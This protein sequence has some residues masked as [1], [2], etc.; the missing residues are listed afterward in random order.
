[1]A[2]SIDKFGTV[3]SSIDIN[4]EEINLILKSLM[5]VHKETKDLIL[6]DE[7][8]RLMERFLDIE[9]LIYGVENVQ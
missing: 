3:S 8:N 1:M 4:R 7:I 5:T 6:I 2:V 9:Q